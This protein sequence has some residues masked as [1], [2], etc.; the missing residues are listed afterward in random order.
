MEAPHL[1]LRI[2]QRY[3]LGDVRLRGATTDKE[4]KRVGGI[5]RQAFTIHVN[6]LYEIEKRSR[7]GKVQ[8]S[9]FYVQKRKEGNEIGWAQGRKNELRSDFDIQKT[10]LKGTKMD[11]GTPGGKYHS[12]GDVG[13]DFKPEKT[14]TKRRKMPTLRSKLRPWEGQGSRKR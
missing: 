8:R 10:R 14:W 6:S 3:S 5:G 12:L 7:S 2:L 1:D 4:T 13:S 9:D 11:R